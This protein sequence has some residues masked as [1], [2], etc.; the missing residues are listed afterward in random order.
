MSFRQV[1]ANR[2][3]PS[4]W[5]RFCCEVLKEY[6]VLD[7][8]VVGVRR[9]ESRA[10]KDRYKEPETCRV[11]N[12]TKGIKSRQYLP[13][14]DWTKDDVA[15]FLNERGVRCHPLY[16]DDGG[17][18]HPERRLGCMCCPL[19]SKKKR[20]AEFKRFPRMARFYIRGIKEYIATHPNGKMVQKTGGNAYDWFT[21]QVFC[22]GWGEFVERFGRSEL[23]DDKIDTKKYLENEFNIEL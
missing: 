10:R 22:D 14:L 3:M 4:R 1:L 7:Y 11:Y 6:K 2:G 15:A 9:D 12:K 21:S 20:I 23:F 16:Y 8:A 13:I 17:V 19:Q 18:F 5:R